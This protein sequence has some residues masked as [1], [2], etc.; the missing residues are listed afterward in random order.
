MGVLG[1]G[2]V[3]QGPWVFRSALGFRGP[4]IGWELLIFFFWPFKGPGSPWGH[5]SSA[6][7]GDFVGTAAIFC[8][9]ENSFGVGPWG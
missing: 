7:L 5:I 1:K 3:P 9:A 8:R 4:F 2:R 6:V